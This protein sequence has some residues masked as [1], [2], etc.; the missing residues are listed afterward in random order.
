MLSAE[1]GITLL[2]VEVISVCQN[3]NEVHR[4]GFNFYQ[5]YTN[6]CRKRMLQTINSMKKITSGWMGTRGSS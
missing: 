4:H 6:D 5:R 3:R 1:K 2:E